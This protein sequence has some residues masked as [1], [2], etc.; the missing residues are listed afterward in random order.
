MSTVRGFGRAIGMIG[1]ASDLIARLD[2]WPADRAALILADW[3]F[4]PGPPTP[5]DIPYAWLSNPLRARPDT[6]ITTTAV[7][8]SGT[9]GASANL[10]DNASLDEYGDNLFTASLLTTLAADPPALA[11]HMLDHYATQPGDVPRTRFP[12][13]TL[14]IFARTIPEQQRILALAIGTRIRITG[15]PASWPV[16]S[17]SQVIEGIHH[18]LAGNARYVELNTA[19]AVVGPWFRTDSSAMGETHTTPF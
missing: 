17:D 14:N 6:P 2:V 9:G 7:S 1:N 4:P 16:G 15:V 3:M 13:L 12:S 10:A 8:Q 18:V 19:P 11:R 5:V